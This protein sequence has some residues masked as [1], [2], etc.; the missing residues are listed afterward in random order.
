MGKKVVLQITYGSSMLLLTRMAPW[1][2]G[3]IKG[4]IS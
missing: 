3:Q 1:H 4:S 2:F